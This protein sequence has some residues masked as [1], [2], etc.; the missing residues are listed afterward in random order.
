MFQ[1]MTLTLLVLLAGVFYYLRQRRKR[2]EQQTADRRAF[3]RAAEM[4]QGTRCSIC[5]ERY[6]GL[7][8]DCRCTNWGM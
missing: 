1:T 6:V 8:M 5:G 4:A 7:A 3:H 2:R